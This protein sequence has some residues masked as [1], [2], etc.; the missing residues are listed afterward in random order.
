MVGC[1]VMACAGT[2]RVIVPQGGSHPR[3]PHYR[4]DEKFGIYLFFNGRCVDER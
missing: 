3:E 4:S 2:A 1:W